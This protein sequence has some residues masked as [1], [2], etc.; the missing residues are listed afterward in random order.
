MVKK[1]LKIV[2]CQLH[3]LI[4]SEIITF[5]NNNTFRSFLVVFLF[6]R[7]NYLLEK[8]KIYLFKI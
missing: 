6:T 1:Y 2:F 3:V 4:V 7:E 8:S 5:D